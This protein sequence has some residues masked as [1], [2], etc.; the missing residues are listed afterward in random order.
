[1]NPLA[2]AARQ[3]AGPP[4]GAEALL[5]GS[6]VVLAGA[7]V[8]P[9][10]VSTYRRLE[11]RCMDVLAP[12]IFLLL[13]GVAIHELAHAVVGRRYADVEIDWTVPKVVLDWHDEVPIWG[14]VGV[15]LAPLWVGGVTAFALAV[16]L[17]MAPPA[18]VAWLV[19]NWILLAGPSVLD[20]VTLVAILRAA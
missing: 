7:V 1:M 5:V 6:L 13:P 15:Y 11:R 10:L 4:G 18:V 14:P 19:I 3:V 2:E 16:V 17:P 8:V 20:V 12:W 9:P